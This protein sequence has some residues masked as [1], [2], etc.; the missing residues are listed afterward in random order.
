M[1]PNVTAAA[2]GF[3]EIAIC[4]REITL[5]ILISIHQAIA[6]G[7]IPAFAGHRRG[8]ACP[9]HPCVLRERKSCRSPL[10]HPLQQALAHD[11]AWCVGKVNPSQVVSYNLLGLNLY[12][13]ESTD[14]ERVHY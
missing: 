4:A 11:A 7:L 8:D 10:L 3:A 9:S 1:K 6:I 12:D 14:L 13:I 2:R 5:T